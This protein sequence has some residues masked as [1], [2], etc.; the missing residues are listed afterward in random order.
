MD[1]ITSHYALHIDNFYNW[2]FGNYAELGV[3]SAWNIM[4][5][6]DS[7]R[8]CPGVL[9]VETN[10][11]IGGAGKIEYF[12]AG[13]DRYFDFYFEFNDCF[14]GCDNYRKWS[15]MVDP[16]CTVY[17]LG[18]TDWGVFGISPLPAPVNCNLFTDINDIPEKD[19]VIFPNP[20][21]NQLAVSSRQYAINSTSIYNISGE[22]VMRPPMQ[23]VNSQHQVEIDVHLLPPGIYF[24]DVACD[25][26]ISHTR[27]IKQ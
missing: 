23:C 11:L 14:D 27:F 10:G 19:M 4:A 22:L 6:M 18:F 15:F 7:I 3:D 20:V 5:L 26:Y 16:N 24:L 25:E 8:Y 21:I 1:S 9:F 17:Y 12:K 2:S 13:N